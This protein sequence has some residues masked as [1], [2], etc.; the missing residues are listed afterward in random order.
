MGWRCF[1]AKPTEFVGISLRRYSVNMLACHKRYPGGQP[2]YHN[3]EVKIADVPMALQEPIGRPP[4]PVE[5]AD[6]R[7]PKTCECGYAFHPEDYWQWNATALYSG[8]P[9]G[10]LYT[11]HELPPGAIWHCPWLDDLKENPYAGPDGKT[12]ALQLPA[13]IEWLIYG[14]SS[15]KGQKWDVRGT[16]PN[17]TVSP[18][19]AQIGYYHGFVKQGIVTKDC[20]GRKFP[21]W[22]ETAEEPKG[23]I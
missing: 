6:P 20:D 10:K 12:W 15:T 3:A 9:D 22:P 8:A 4:D 5:Q 2:T 14:P 18:S 19:I 13:G 16:L 7:W 17:I 23:N 11:L 21:E 1:M